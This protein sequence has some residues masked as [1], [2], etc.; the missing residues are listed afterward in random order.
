MTAYRYIPSTP[1]DVV[2]RLGAMS[3]CLPDHPLP[4]SGLDMQG[5]FA[6]LHE[7]LGII[8]PRIG[9]ERFLRATEMAKESEQFYVG[10]D[11]LAGG[12]MLREMQKV[13][14]RR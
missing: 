6:E 8:R 13:I 10:G 2:D 5:A 12:R 14:A 9:D 3:L 4:S 1:G 7:S 11:E